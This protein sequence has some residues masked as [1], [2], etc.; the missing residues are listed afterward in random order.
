MTDFKPYANESDEQE[1]GNLKVE[2]RLDHI[3]IYGDLDITRDQRGLA[4]ARTLKLLVDRIVRALESEQL[5]EKLAA[6][7]VKKVKNPF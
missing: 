7:V 3:S 6:P 2:N 1:I 4:S 5:P